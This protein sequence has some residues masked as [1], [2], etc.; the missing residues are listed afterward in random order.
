MSWE[1]PSAKAGRR[2]T[3]IDRAGFGAWAG[4][5]SGSGTG[6]NLSKVL[7]QGGQISAWVVW[8]YREL[9]LKSGPLCCSVPGC[10]SVTLKTPLTLRWWQNAFFCAA[11]G[12]CAG[13]RFCS[14]AGAPCSNSRK[15][16]F[17]NYYFLNDLFI[18]KML[19]AQTP[20]RKSLTAKL[21]EA[22]QISA[23]VTQNPHNLIHLLLINASFPEC[24]SCGGFMMCVPAPA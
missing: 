3:V 6:L 4:S 7:R 20:N 5:G 16:L 23:D 17:F 24:I 22:A 1:I 18:M 9:S 21:R 2:E 11:A 8:S 10:P 12:L 15:G 14:G 13:V 19:A